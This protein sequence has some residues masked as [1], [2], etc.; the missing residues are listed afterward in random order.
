MTMLTLPCQ[1]LLCLRARRTTMRCH[2]RPFSPLRQSQDVGGEAKKSASPGG[3]SLSPG[4]ESGNPTAESPVV[5][6][7]GGKSRSPGVESESPRGSLSRTQKRCRSSWPLSVPSSTLLSRAKAQQLSVPARPNLSWPQSVPNLRD[8]Y[9]SAQQQSHR[10]SPMPR[11]PKH[12][13]ASW[14]LS[15]QRGPG[16][17]RRRARVQMRRRHAQT[18][19]CCRLLSRRLR[20]L[21]A[22]SLSARRTSA[23]S[24]NHPRHPHTGLHRLPSATRQKRGGQRPGGRRQRQK[25]QL[26]AIAKLRLGSSRRTRRQRRVWKRRRKRRTG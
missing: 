25:K 26:G 24:P 2:L 13:R 16:S 7:P 14:R 19:L 5:G 3:D 23:P 9:Y 4:G 6:S 17:W 22:Q 21:S 15:S 20:G 10:R 12:G 8:S 11:R 1:S 18:R